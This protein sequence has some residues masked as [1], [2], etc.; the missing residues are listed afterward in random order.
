MS[1]K[2]KLFSFHIGCQIHNEFLIFKSAGK[3]TFV[4]RH[5]DRRRWAATN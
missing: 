3:I 5:V 1:S 2:T 4:S